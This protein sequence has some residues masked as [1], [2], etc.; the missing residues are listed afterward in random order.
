MTVPTGDSIADKIHT[1]NNSSDFSG[2][3]RDLD[4]DHA[5]RPGLWHQDLAKV[6]EALHKQGI[7]PGVD[8][9]GTNGQDLIGRKADGSTVAIDATK[10]TRE[11]DDHSGDGSGSHTVKAGE[12]AWTVARDQLK[13]EG[14]DKPTNNQIANYIKELEKANGHSLTKLHAGD[15]IK[16]PASVKQGEQTEFRGDRANDTAQQKTDKLNTDVADAKEALGKY[17][18]KWGVNVFNSAYMSHDQIKEALKG[19]GLTDQDKEGLQFLDKNFDQ[20]AKKGEKYVYASE[21][22]P[23]R[24]AQA[25]QIEEARTTAWRGR[26]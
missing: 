12:N 25:D 24:K 2:I 18:H 6:N 21:L 22:E 7:L 23:Y 15:Q 20:I 5:H 14:T 16:L 8:L 1:M 10:V 3:V 13:Q 19:S 26:D 9:V 11:K 4:Q 17:T